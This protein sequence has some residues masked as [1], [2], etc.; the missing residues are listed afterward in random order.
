MGRVVERPVAD[1]QVV[2]HCQRI[3]QGFTVLKG[4]VDR[5]EDPGGRR[6]RR[7]NEDLGVA[8]IG[9]LPGDL[10]IV[11]LRRTVSVSVAGQLGRCSPIPEEDLVVAAVPAL[12]GDLAVVDLRRTVSVSVAG[13]IGHGRPVPEVDLGVAAVPALPDDLAVVDLRII[14]SV[15]VAGQL[16]G[17]GA[18]PDKDLVVALPGD[19][20]VV[21]L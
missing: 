1:P 19:L 17:V 4:L 8:A 12:P 9:A 14:V 20:A 15:S 7:G 5:S 10:A 16:G 18:V 2:D 3:I 13:D 21:D 11:D 6:V